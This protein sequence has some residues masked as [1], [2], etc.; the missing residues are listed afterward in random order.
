VA[1]IY[2]IPR[3]SIPFSNGIVTSFLY[4]NQIFSN[5]SHLCG[6]LKSNWQG[7]TGFCIISQSGND[8]QHLLEHSTKLEE[9]RSDSN[10]EISLI[11]TWLATLRYEQSYSRLSRQQYDP[12][13]E[14]DGSEYLINEESFADVV[15]VNEEVSFP[16]SVSWQRRGGLSGGATNALPSSGLRSCSMIGNVNGNTATLM[17]HSSSTRSTMVVICHSHLMSPTITSTNTTH[18]EDNE[19]ENSSPENGLVENSSEVELE[20]MQIYGDELH[21]HDNDLDNDFEEDGS[22]EHYY[23]VVN[24]ARLNYLEDL[25]FV[26]QHPYQSPNF[27]LEGRVVLKTDS[28]VKIGTF[29][30]RPLF[31]RPHALS[32]GCISS[33]EQIMCIDMGCMRIIM[34]RLFVLPEVKTRMN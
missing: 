6:I 3:F 16:F 14:E 19:S 4:E 2:D 21:I 11:G 28:V 26:T 17:L 34:I 13:D 32:L 5:P 33:R 23:Q 30:A 27:F 12:Y 25:S 22:D 20:T 15:D 29:F 24:N 10:N 1:H 18:H 9:L 8:S 7:I 31:K